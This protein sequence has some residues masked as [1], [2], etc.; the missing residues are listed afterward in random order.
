MKKY[1]DV[2][3]TQE[4]HCCDRC[5][6]ELPPNATHSINLGIYQSQIGSKVFWF[7]TTCTPIVMEAVT[8]MRAK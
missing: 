5:D 7:C 3:V 6:V 2:A 8:L 1:R 4:Y